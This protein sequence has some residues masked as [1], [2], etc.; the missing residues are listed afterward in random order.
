MFE[1]AAAF[2]AQGLLDHAIEVYAAL[3]E[4]GRGG[5]EAMMRKGLLHRQLGEVS[6]ATHSFEQ[7]L[8]AAPGDPYPLMRLG[9]LAEDLGRLMASAGFMRG[10]VE[11]ATRDGG[12]RLQ[13]MQVNLTLAYTRLQWLDTAREVARSLPEGLPDWWAGAREKAL[14]EFAS[15]RSAAR[16]L[17][18]AR[19]QRDLSPDEELTLARHMLALG[20]LKTARAICAS[21]MPRHPDWHVLT[22]FMADVAARAG[23]AE[24]ALAVMRADPRLPRDTIEYIGSEVRLLQELDRWEEILQRLAE[25]PQVPRFPHVRRAGVTAL[26]R[27]GRL[28]ALKAYCVEGMRREPMEVAPAASIVFLH[29]RKAKI[30]PGASQS[31]PVRVM[32]FWDSPTVPQDV[33]AAMASWTRLNPGWTHVLYDLAGARDFFA[34]HLDP[35]ALAALDLCFHPAMT[36]DLFRLGFLHVC[37]GVYVDADE[38]CLR[39][40]ESLLPDLAHAE[41]A[42][43]LAGSFPGYIDNFFIAAKAGGEV[44]GSVLQEAIANILQAHREGRRP[45][46]WQVTGPG[47]L[48]RGV[49]RYLASGDRSSADVA[50]LPM[51]QYRGCVQT[52]GS[53]AYKR[54]AAANWRISELR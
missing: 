18:E 27:L 11:L 46:I 22:Y 47:A 9:Q 44:T 10:A 31:R 34:T 28:E 21:L 13:E 15:A 12:S 3:V 36:A 14:S 2:E 23:G 43:A 25:T 52:D 53:L 7:A 51:Q 1:A 20:R 26:L 32:Q 30:A 54:D 50:L 16:A 41:I 48:T 42:A 45:D 33:Q 49:A 5:A 24:A 39:P 40:M 35:E 37:G 19:R 29:A 8:A 6:Q 17:L 4:Q 38:L